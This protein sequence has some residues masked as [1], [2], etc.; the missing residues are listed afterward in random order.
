MLSAAFCFAA[1]GFSFSSAANVPDTAGHDFFE[2]KIR[3]IFVDH[4]YE[5]HS[6]AGGK[7]KG[8]LFLDSKDGV[9]KGG[10]SG[11]AIVPGDPEKS[12]MIKAVRYAD[13]NLQMP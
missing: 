12:L 4:C 9:L 1:M 8:S 10:D 3:P 13:E 6:H 7:S 2:S 5:C 11:P